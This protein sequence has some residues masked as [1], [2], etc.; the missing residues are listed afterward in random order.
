MVAQYCQRTPNAVEN[1]FA[2]TR[3]RRGL[4]AAQPTVRWSLD[5]RPRMRRTPKQIGLAIVGAGR[6][7]LLR[8]QVAARHGAVGW[9]G[10]AEKNPERA[11]EVARRIGADFITGD[12][13]ERLPPPA[14]KPATTPTP[15][16]RPMFPGN[17]PIERR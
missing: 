13:R 6:V 9:I 14:G 8:G 3:V 7:G 2:G 15:R 17:G 4:E 10:I 1:E 5:G 11:R 16:H 12:D